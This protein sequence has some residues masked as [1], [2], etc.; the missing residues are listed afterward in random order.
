MF[1]SG[2]MFA[3]QMSGGD[4][5]GYNGVSGNKDCQF[6]CRGV[7]KNFKVD[8]LTISAGSLSQN[9]KARTLNAC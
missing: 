1:P 3:E 6:A 8:T 9:E 7:L 2:I 4:I 5:A